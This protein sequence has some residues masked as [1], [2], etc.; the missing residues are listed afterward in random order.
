MPTP[1]SS[2]VALRCVKRWYDSDDHFIPHLPPDWSSASS[3]SI[4]IGSGWSEPVTYE[5]ANC[6]RSWLPPDGNKPASIGLTTTADARASAHPT[7]VSAHPPGFLT[8]KI[9]DRTRSNIFNEPLGGRKRGPGRVMGLD[10][11]FMVHTAYN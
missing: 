3:A 7:V 5:G 11:G 9:R 1:P 6:Q 10:W 8:S 2:G 4:P